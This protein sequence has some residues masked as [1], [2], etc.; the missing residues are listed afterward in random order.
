MSFETV[1]DYGYLRCGCNCGRPYPVRPLVQN[2]S[3][4]GLQCSKGRT[5]YSDSPLSVCRRLSVVTGDDSGPGPIPLPVPS[6]RARLRTVSG[7]G[8]DRLCQCVINR[9]SLVYQPKSV[10][11]NEKT[12]FVLF[13]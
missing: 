1:V 5:L 12:K 3:D 11:S 13:V 8:R 9:T 10:M 7:Y 2:E 6:F 4:T